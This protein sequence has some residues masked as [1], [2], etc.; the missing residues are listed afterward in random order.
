MYQFPGGLI[1]HDICLWQLTQFSY[2]NIGDCRGV[3]AIL[4]KMF[5]SIC[6]SSDAGICSE[7]QFD[8]AQTDFD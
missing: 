6:E 1:V 2:K 4:K 7:K 3:N 5:Y 8:L